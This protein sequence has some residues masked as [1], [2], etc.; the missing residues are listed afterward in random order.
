MRAAYNLFAG[1]QDFSNEKKNP[2]G[3]LVANLEFLME[4]NAGVLPGSP[5]FLLEK[6]PC[7]LAGN[8]DFRGKKEPASQQAGRNPGSFFPRKSGCF[9][10]GPDG[11]RLS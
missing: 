5:S 10:Q 7:R 1:N 6:N 11:G 2:A 3:M 9:S 4:E 8:P